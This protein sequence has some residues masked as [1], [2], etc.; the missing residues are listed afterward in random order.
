MLTLP[1]NRILLRTSFFLIGL[2]LFISCDIAEKTSEPE[3]Q[4][5]IDYSPAGELSPEQIISYYDNPLIELIASYDVKAYRITYRTQTIDGT[6]VT[7]SGMILV[8]SITRPS[9]LV[10]QRGTLFQKSEAP[11]LFDPDL[12]DNNSVWTY[13]GPVVSSSG[14]MIIM[15]DLLGFGESESLFHPY[16]VT[17]SHGRVSLDMMKAAEE[18]F[19]MEGI[20]K[21]NRLFITGYS[22]GGTSAMALLKAIGEDAS[23]DFRVT[24]AS[25]GGGAY[26]LVDVSKSILGADTLGFAPNYAYIVAA[27]D[28]TY[29]LNR[30]IETIF[31]PP[32]SSRIFGENL[33]GGQF[34]GSQIDE[35]LTNVTADLF[36]ES[37]LA[38]FLGGGEQQLKELLNSNDVSGFRVQVPLRIYHGEFDEVVPVDE[39]RN[40]FEK[41][42]DAGAA[43]IQFVLI[44]DGTHESSALD[45]ASQTLNWFFVQ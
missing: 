8:P 30:D 4:Y 39:A 32:Y 20:G 14:Y 12:A 27:Y 31:K 45:F 19:D 38:G 26:N 41:L 7:A 36:Q 16:F 9:V 23:A 1:M 21:G 17:R 3:L 24:A 43:N 15:P 22:Q 5:L 34:S 13:F 6:H 44:P 28:R 40:A 37:F 29:N 35:R 42:K 11:S 2:L 33:F 10:L 18:F 25:V